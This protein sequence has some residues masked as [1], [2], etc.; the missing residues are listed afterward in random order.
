VD[1]ERAFV[2]SADFTEAARTRNIE[3]GVLLRS[4]PFARRLAAHLEMLAALQT[5]S[6]RPPVYSRPG[7][8]GKTR[9]RNFLPPGR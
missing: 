1:R 9:C 5:H 4:P 2:S 8:T 7:K 6:P 3:V